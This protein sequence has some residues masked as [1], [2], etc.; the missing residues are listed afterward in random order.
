MDT[1]KGNILMS[2]NITTYPTD[3]LNDAT[4]FL[5]QAYSMVCIISGEGLEGFNQH[6]TEVKNAYFEVCTGL[7]RG[8][9][10][11]TTHDGLT[12]Q[13]GQASAMIDVISAHGTDNFNLH[14]SA[15]QD[16]YLAACLTVLKEAQ[17]LSARL[18]E[19]ELKVVNQ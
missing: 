18:F 17:D 1:A 4:G 10:N 14:S 19:V 2:E 5:E 16:S 7:L 12:K 6:K 3:V 8:A 9:Q 11:L 15:I 13:L